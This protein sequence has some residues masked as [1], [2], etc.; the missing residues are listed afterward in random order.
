MKIKHSYFGFFISILVIFPVVNSVA[1]VA[2]DVNYVGFDK[3]DVY[4]WDIRYEEEEDLK[5]GM[6]MGINRTVFD[7]DDNIK[8]WKHVITW[9]GEEDVYR[10]NKGVKYKVNQYKSESRGGKD[11]EGYD[12]KK[13][14][15]GKEYTII[16]YQPDNL[17]VR[18][19]YINS[20]IFGY[21]YVATNVEWGNL[22]KELS[23]DLGA[24]V[25]AEYNERENSIKITIWEDYYILD[26]Q[27]YETERL[28]ITCDYTNDGILEYYILKNEG[29]TV[30]SL[31][32]R[33]SFWEENWL[34]I[35]ETLQNNI[36][37]VITFISIIIVLLFFFVTRGKRP[38]YK[39][40]ISRFSTKKS[41]LVNRESKLN[42]EKSLEKPKYCPYC[43]KSQPTLNE[44]CV[45]CGYSLKK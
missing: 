37:L 22:M 44:Y 21:L 23:E 39:K 12:W 17:H 20:A 14:D 7:I 32:L 18:N 26:E 9:M 43:G 36:L 41:N 25:A 42:E 1:V 15:E 3:N 24:P 35:S 33:K 10:G 34:R 30:L 11:G 27:K 40:I 4:I 28:D 8:A 16:K 31:T 2:H 13:D 45:F 6:K 19:Y 29:D 38:I 5:M